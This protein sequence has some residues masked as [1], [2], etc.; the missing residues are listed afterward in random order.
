M[1]AYTDYPFTELGD[2]S[3]KQ[4]PIRSCI[5]VDY[6]DNKYCTIIVEGLETCIKRG[7]IYSKFGRCGEVPC[8]SVEGLPINNS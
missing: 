4:A 3:G 7:Y 8:I 2:V 1:Q 6:D 5:V